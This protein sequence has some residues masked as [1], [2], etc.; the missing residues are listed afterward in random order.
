[1]SGRDDGRRRPAVFWIVTKRFGMS[2]SVQWTSD[3]AVATIRVRAAWSSRGED[4]L[5]RD[6]HAAGRDRG[7]GLPDAMS[8]L[9]VELAMRPVCSRSGGGYSPAAGIPL[10]GNMMNAFNRS[11]AAHVHD[12]S[13]QGKPILRATPGACS[14]I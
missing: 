5:R 14:S 8:M 11:S 4:R 7:S 6:S 2:M 12:L 1:M 3:C 9:S 10:Y 13:A